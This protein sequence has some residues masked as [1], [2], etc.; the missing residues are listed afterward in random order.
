M[1][2]PVGCRS[3]QQTSHCEANPWR[4]VPL[5]QVHLWGRGDNYKTSKWTFLFNT[6]LALAKE[7]APECIQCNE[8][9]TM[10]LILLDCIDFLPIRDKHYSADNMYNL[11]DTVRIDSIIAFI[12]EIGLYIKL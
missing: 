2:I 3:F 10:K 4:V 7:D 6:L 12:K 8:Y 9:L 5:L 11:F 1:A